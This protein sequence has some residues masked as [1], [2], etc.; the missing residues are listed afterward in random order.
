M[1][2]L[3]RSRRCRRA[4]S[5]LDVRGNIWLNSGRVKLGVLLLLVVFLAS[6]CCVPLCMVDP[7]QGWVVD[8][9]TG[10]PITG[11]LV[12]RT[13]DYAPKRTKTNRK[14][15]FRFH[16]KWIVTIPLGDALQS[17][18]TY[19]IE[20]AGYEGC[21]TNEFEWHPGFVTP[22]SSQLCDFGVIKLKPKR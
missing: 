4:D 13:S 8:A 12:T 5:I 21:L 20:A 18:A 11:A 19:H 1:S 14:G 2:E 17:D 9:S 10:K 6:G 22:F 7:A 3:T 15:Y 16:G